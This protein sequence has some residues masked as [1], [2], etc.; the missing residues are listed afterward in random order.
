MRYD[1]DITP[2]I[3]K[4]MRS[5]G[6]DLRSCPP[7]RVL[8]EDNSTDREIHFMAY[9]LVNNHGQNFVYRNIIPSAYVVG[10]SQTRTGIKHIRRVCLDDFIKAIVLNLFG[11]PHTNSLPILENCLS[12]LL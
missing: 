11:S 10:S 8:L 4:E 9:S 3:L 12:S 5:V 1:A 6:L 2:E 7:I